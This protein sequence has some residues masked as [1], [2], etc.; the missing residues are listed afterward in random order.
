[1]R[2]PHTRGGVSNAVI[3]DLALAKSSPHTWG[4]FFPK[5]IFT[6]LT[7]VF[8]T[9]VGVF[10]QSFCNGLK[11]RLSSPHTW[12]C[13]Q[14]DIRLIHHAPVFPT[15]VGVFPP[16]TRPR[17][18][19][20]RLPHTRG[21]VSHSLSV[22]T[23]GA[24]SSPH[25]WGCFYGCQRNLCRCPVFPTHVGVFLPARLH[26]GGLGGLPHTRGGVSSFP[27]ARPPAGKSSPHTWGCFCTLKFFPV[28]HNVFPTHV[29]VFPPWI[30]RNNMLLCL[31]HTRGG[32]SQYAVP[33]YLRPLSS[34]HTWGCFL[35]PYSPPAPS[36]PCSR[37][38]PARTAG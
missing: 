11:L 14:L 33:P 27:I 15:H 38:Y 10:P 24:G 2:L 37:P 4:C 34:P 16:E 5:P 25:T 36:L 28:A 30:Y 29:G 18:A 7:L 17:S 26:P 19:S 22:K 8:P 32:V 20:C 31:P 3:E 35:K 1:M 21:G 13:F 12:G 9:H 6:A 23:R